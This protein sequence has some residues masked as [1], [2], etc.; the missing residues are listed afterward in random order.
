MLNCKFSTPEKAAIGVKSGC[1]FF[2]KQGGYYRYQHSDHPVFWRGV[3]TS[4][5]VSS[6]PAS[7][8]LH[9]WW[10]SYFVPDPNL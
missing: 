3:R 10:G 5:C 8:R 6:S 4:V 2:E 7:W 9:S 1:W